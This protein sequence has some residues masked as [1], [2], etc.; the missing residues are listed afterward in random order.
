[1]F[2]KC[3]SAKILLCLLENEELLVNGCLEREKKIT[4]T[5]TGTRQFIKDKY[6]EVDFSKLEG[7]GWKIDFED[8]EK[9][10]GDIFMYGP[11][12][13]KEKINVRKGRS[14]GL[15]DTFVKKNFMSLGKSADTL[16]KESNA[17]IQEE[18]KRL[19][20]AEKQLKET[21]RLNEE[22]EKAVQ[23][24]KDLR[25][26]IE[27]NQA[28]IDQLGS[29]MENESELRELQQRAKNYR[30]DLENAKKE[31]TALE[32]QAKQKESA[33]RKEQARYAQ[34]RDSLA[35]KES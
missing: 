14:W 2:L 4:D 35:A 5:V 6:P 16:L 28:R 13:G 8:P 18:S 9:E 31:V 33:V 21:E 12:G 10:T 26:R 34:I 3:L 22:K 7:G 15:S 17:E 1:M 23:E 20:E 32:K 29:N 30:T 11:R 27:R 25:I 19:C 24:V